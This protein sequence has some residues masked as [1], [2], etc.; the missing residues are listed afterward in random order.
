MSGFGLSHLLQIEGLRVHTSHEDL[1]TCES[2]STFSKILI[3]SD[4]N[5]SHEFLHTYIDM[6]SAWLIPWNIVVS[7]VLAPFFLQGYPLMIIV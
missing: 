5:M 2:L 6:Y 7:R 1:L 4:M 3:C